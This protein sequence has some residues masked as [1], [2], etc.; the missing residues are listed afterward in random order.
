MSN[1]EVTAKDAILYLME[2]DGFVAPFDLPEDIVAEHIEVCLENFIAAPELWE[3]YKLDYCNAKYDYRNHL[4]VE[5]HGGEVTAECISLGQ[6]FTKIINS[7]YFD[8][9]ANFQIGLLTYSLLENSD[10]A[11]IFVSFTDDSIS[12]KLQTT[13]PGNH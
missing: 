1:N 2:N 6:R 12:G 7:E 13:K 9:N 3:L 4:L 10:F 11:D 8:S 5:S